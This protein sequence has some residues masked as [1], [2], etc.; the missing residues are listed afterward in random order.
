[1]IDRLENMAFPETAKFKYPWRTYQQRVLDD[2]QAH[3]EDKHLHVIAPPGSGKTVLGLEVALRLNKPTLILA[4]TTAIRNQWIQR[5]C[6]LFLQAHDVPD[7]ISRD[8]RKPK[9]MTVATYQG[10][11][12]ACNGQAIEE[13]DTAEEE[14]EN[15]GVGSAGPT[16]A[17][18]ETV[19]KELMERQVQ[20]IVVDEAHHL[21][22]EWWQT[23]TKI[24]DRLDPVIV[25]LTATPPYDV[26]ATEWQRYSELNGPVDAEIAVPELVIAG[27]LCPHQDLVYCTL[28]SEKEHVEIADF[29]ESMAALFLELKADPVLLNAIQRLTIWT[30]PGT[31]LNWIYQNIPYYS[32][33]LIFLNAHGVAI[34][35]KHLEIVGDKKLKVPALDYVWMETLLDFYLY[36]G[37]QWFKPHA[38]H[39]I[40]VE[41]RLRRH[42]ALDRRQISFTQNR[43]LVGSLVS[44]VSKLSAIRSIVDFEYRHLGSALRLVVLAD[45]IRAEYFVNAAENDLPLNRLG[46]MPIFEQLRRE[47][48]DGKK[49]GVLT[50]SLVIIPE[51]AYPSFQEKASKYGIIAAQ[52]APLPYDGDYRYVRQTE[53]LKHDIVNIITQIFQE[54]GIEVLVGTKSLLGE[55]WDAPAI[56]TLVLASY[57]GSFVLSNQ[58]RGRAIRTEKGNAEKTGN[59]WHLACV[60]PTV[61]RG[62]E[63]IARLKRRFR[64]FVGVCVGNEPVIENGIGRMNLPDNLWQPRVLDETNAAMMMTA[65][66]RRGVSER[67]HQALLKGINLVEEIKIPFVEDRP[68]RQVKSMYLNKT[69]ANLL[70]TLTSGLVAFG[71][72]SLNILSR[73]MRNMRSP[74]DLYTFLAI[75]GGIGLVIF[76]RMTFKTARLYL[77]YRDIALDIQGIGHALLDTLVKSGAIHTDRDKLRVVSEVDREGGVY[78]YLDGGSTFEQSQFIS[79]LREIVAPVMNPRYV[80]IRKN[81]LFRFIKQKDFHAVPDALSKNRKLAGYFYDRWETHVG[82]GELVSLRT[83]AGRKLLLKARVKALAT[84]LEDQVEHVNKWR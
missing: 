4:P 30:D 11:H 79:A 77:Q 15:K 70:A 28:P 14:E 40:S 56:N 13:E 24:K 59:I 35:E 26:T 76:G 39:Q 44:S 38:K 29:R 50:G 46:V 58:M 65:A 12:A 27:D 19:A 42:G 83:I 66:D 80:I 74:Q 9:F 6:E 43:R 8:I 41:N 68:Y 69:M 78:C 37:G 67:W 36:R 49:I 81:R 47:N 53:Q 23:L 84:Q 52:A 34:P 60:D 10:L 45:Y 61:A 31:E 72:E 48:T 33:C 63:D 18:L 7:W 5:F 2:L 62:G 21:K 82:P 20:T 22:N 55:G 64:S 73:A 71:N 32:S 17:N 75:I 3:I 51:A 57:V 54:G 1:M 16:N 25:G